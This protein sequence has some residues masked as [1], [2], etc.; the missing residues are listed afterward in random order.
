MSPQPLTLGMQDRIVAFETYLRVERRRGASTTARYVDIVRSFVAH[1]E[2]LASGS[3]LAVA[4]RNDCLEF[5]RSGTVVAGEPSRSVWNLRLSALRAFYQY[6]VDL[7]VIAKNPTHR[8]ERHKIASR[9]PIPLSMTE[10]LDLVEA[11]ERTSPLVRSR[12]VAIVQ[13]LYNTALRVAEVVSLDVDRVDWDAYAF[14]DVRTKG[15]K[16]LSAKF[17]DLV[18]GVLERYLGDRARRKIISEGALFVSERGTR[19]S[20]RAVQQLVRDLGTAAGIQRPVTPHLLRHSCA[21]E[22]V[23]LGTGLKVVQQICG[24]AS[25]S[26]TE[27]YVHVRAGADRAAIDALGSAVDRGLKARRRAA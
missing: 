24:H 11:A 9:E 7:E 26:T 18:A 22:L 5:L 2:A 21:T 14:R 6:L 17:P 3:D 20:I 10:F 15:N 13:V 12:N 27:R 25:Q 19:L 8:I 16:W 4:D 1:R 23:D